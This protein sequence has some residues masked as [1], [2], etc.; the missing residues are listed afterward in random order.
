LAYRVKAS[1]AHLSTTEGT[2]PEINR[3][4]CRLYAGIVLWSHKDKRRNF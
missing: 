2:M 3:L 4:T 1:I